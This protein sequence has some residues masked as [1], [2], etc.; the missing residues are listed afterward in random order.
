M[1]TLRRGIFQVEFDC[2]LLSQLPHFIFKSCIFQQFSQALFF[3]GGCWL[4]GLGRLTFS[5]GGCCGL[6]KLAKLTFTKLLAQLKFHWWKYF[7]ANSNSALYL[8][9]LAKILSPAVRQEV[10]Q[11]G[12]EHRT[13]NTE[14]DL[15]CWPSQKCGQIKAV[16]VSF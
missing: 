1:A 12:P 15:L 8:Y 4:V 13:R 9:L 7:N 11:H 5:H 3:F 6:C 16:R 10:W 14:V 2:L